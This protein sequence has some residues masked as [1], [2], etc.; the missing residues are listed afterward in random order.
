MRPNSRSIVTVSSD[1]V[2]VAWN[3]PPL[4]E[5]LLSHEPMKFSPLVS[6]PFTVTNLDAGVND[7]PLW[8]G[9]TV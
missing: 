2:A 3:L 8:P 9:V 5:P 6:L 1:V 4:C 7:L